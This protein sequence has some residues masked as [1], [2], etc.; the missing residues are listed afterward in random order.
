MWNAIS[1]LQRC[2]ANAPAPHG[3]TN[4]AAPRFAIGLAAVHGEACVTRPNGGKPPSNGP[5]PVRGGVSRSL[6]YAITP[7]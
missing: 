5:H 2:I 3:A 6:T 7:A 1:T 4:F